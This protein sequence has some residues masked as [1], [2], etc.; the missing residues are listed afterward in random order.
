MKILLTGSSGMVGQNIINHKKFKKYTF[1]IPS[2]SELNLLEERNV[3]SFL[4]SNNPDLIIHAAGFVGGIQSNINSPVDFLLKNS[5]MGINLINKSKELKIKS[6]L[7]L[8]SSC[9]YPANIATKISESML[10]SGPLEPTNEGYAISKILSTKLCEFISKSF[11]EFNYKTI[12]PCNLFGKYDKFDPIKSHLIPAAIMK[13]H[14]AKIY[15]KSV[16]IWGNGD[17][18]REFMYA[19][20]FSN[21]IFYAIENFSEMPHV[22]NV[23]MGIDYTINDYYI[24]IANEIGFNGKFIHDLS[25]PEGMKRKIVDNFKL[26]K[27]GWKPSFSLNE[28]IK[29]TYSYYLETLNG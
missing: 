2:S 26:S 22:M 16:E 24:A 18:R 13:I 7:N 15:D 23:G 21:L 12:I 3:E 27:F 19:E 5:L 1:L 17:A 14:N 11:P 25:K 10:L 6:F 28:G 9:M 4:K 20:D 29:E 8:G